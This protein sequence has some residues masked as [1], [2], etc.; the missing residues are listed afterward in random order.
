[1]ANIGIIAA[2]NQAT[3]TFTATMNDSEHRNERPAALSILIVD[4][5][6]ENLLLLEDVLGELGYITHAAFNGLQALE[7]LAKEE[8]HLIIADA[9]MPKMDGFQLCK[10]VRNSSKHA[11]VPFIIYSS[12]YIDEED[13][14]LARTI[15]ADRY[16]VKTGGTDS[17]LLAVSELM[18][19]AEPKPVYDPDQQ[20]LPLDDHSFI[21]R[22]Y[23]LLIK[24]LEEKMDNLELYS[25]QLLKK[26]EQ[27]QR[28]ERRY[29]LLFEKA[30]VAIFVLDSRGREL[31][32][33][34][35]YAEQVLGSSREE[36]LEARHLPFADSDEREGLVVEPGFSGELT[37]RAKDGRII[38]LETDAAA[39]ESDNEQFILLFSRDTTERKMMMEKLHQSEK[40]SMLGTIAAGIAHEVRN[41]LAGIKLNLQF[42][43]QKYG[44]AFEEIDVLRLAVQGAQHIEKVVENTLTI[45]RT[46]SPEVRSGSINDIVAQAVALLTLTV[47]KKNIALETSLGSDLPVLHLDGKQVLQV[48]LNI[49]RNAIE[50]TPPGG[51]IAVVTGLERPADTGL[52]PRL[53]CTVTD[54]GVGI[55]DEYLKAPFELFKTTKTDGTGL[56]LTLSRRIMQQ[57]GGDILIARPEAGGTQIKLYFPLP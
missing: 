56:G 6:P 29:R 31:V 52:K 13:K 25:M 5:I 50:A 11:S 45:A 53:T 7:V 36:L 40:L 28:S 37:M 23:K 22:H 10:S 38:C 51:S 3:V 20:V 19:I 54:T 2:Q 41:P 35:P 34:N 15:G 49:L 46:T 18:N 16:V 43:E 42:L 32:D 44:D 1:M 48:I 17:L 9:M 47:H 4:D 12:D 55:S 39:I 30:S 57:H 27:L 24:K 8:V 14:E 26:N 21:E 33:V